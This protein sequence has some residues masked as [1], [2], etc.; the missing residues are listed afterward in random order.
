MRRQA[1]I[2]DQMRGRWPMRQAEAPL[3]IMP[4]QTRPEQNPDRHVFAVS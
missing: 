1:T 3:P 4:D 2:A